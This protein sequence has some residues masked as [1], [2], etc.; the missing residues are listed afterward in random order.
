MSTTSTNNHTSS[1]SSSTASG[2]NRFRGDVP[3]FS[4]A[5]KLNPQQ[6]PQQPVHLQQVQQMQYG[7][8][9]IFPNAQQQAAMAAAAAVNSQ[10]MY[11]NQFMPYYPMY[12]NPQYD[13]ANAYSQYQYYSVPPF[14]NPQQFIPNNQMNGGGMHYMNGRPKSKHKNYN[15]NNNNS[16]ANSNH[17]SPRFNQHYQSHNNS[18]NNVYQQQPIPPQTPQQQIHHIPLPPQDQQMFSPNG[19]EPV[20][21]VSTPDPTND[22]DDDV[23]NDDINNDTNNDTKPSPIKTR[24]LS[25]NDLPLH[26]NCTNDD[27]ELFQKNYSSTRKDLIKSKNDRL[28]SYVEYEQQKSFAV[29]D[30]LI[31]TLNNVKIIDLNSNTEY[32]KAIPEIFNNNNE[33][34]AEPKIN[35]STN[36]DEKEKSSGPSS[37]WASVLQSSVVKNIPSSNSTSKKASTSTVPILNPEISSTEASQSIENDASQPIGILVLKILYDP[38]YSSLKGLSP[39]KAK[40]RGLT[41]TGNICYMNAILQALL[42]CEPLSKVLQLID[43]KAIGSLSQVSATPLLDL[44][45]QFYKNFTSENSNSSVNNGIITKAYSPEDFYMSL[46]TQKKFQHLKWGQQE[47]AEEFLCYLLDGLHEEF[48]NSVQALSTPQIDSFI[49]SYQNKF[50]TPAAFSEFKL[51]VKNAIKIIKRTS[52]NDKEEIIEDEDEKND[53]GWSEVGSNNKKISAKRTVEIEP[54]PISRI[55]GGQFRSVLSIPKNKESQSITLDPFQ[56]IQL[57]ISDS[58]INTVEDAF[59]KFNDPEQIPYKSSSNKDVMAKKQTFIDQLP[60]ILLI[61]LKRFSY[62]LEN[63]SNSSNNNQVDSSDSTAE[64]L[65]Q[66]SSPD[67]KFASSML[68]GIEKLRKKIKYSHNL[69]IPQD[70]LS[71][72]IRKQQQ[73]QLSNG[74]VVNSN[75]SYKLTGVIYHHGVS[76]EGGHYTCDVLRKSSVFDSNDESSGKSNDQEWIRIDDTSVSFV[77]K[78]D[79]LEGGTEESTKTAYILLYQRV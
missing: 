46:I 69:I 68:G 2:P 12:G 18:N 23:A 4:P 78:D 53:D 17:K 33:P 58:N 52:T 21:V 32:N 3:S 77:E 59:I 35:E 30:I 24:G 29:N 57:D 48:T 19:S 8:P 66:D 39:F 15:N 47:D 16:N 34:S 27:Y 74:Q 61:Q 72:Y 26:F 31:N 65:P 14:S 40:P 73:Q 75:K 43:E 13:Y 22:D 5:A 38:A 1:S 62:Q 45:I 64:N 10:F 49:L 50:E 56:C 76:A 44:I 51:N 36:N 7:Q 20:S 71:S 41:N 79:V 60:N 67:T 42:F 54:S 6:Q 37:N 63:N 9:P 70:C 28:N 25:A 11:G 55:F